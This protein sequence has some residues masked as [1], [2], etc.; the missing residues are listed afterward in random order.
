MD[1]FLKEYP[2]LIPLKEEIDECL[3]KTVPTDKD[4]ALM[5]LLM[6]EM[7]KFKEQLLEL[8]RLFT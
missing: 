1:E 7:E 8:K 5:I 4:E 3:L 6:C 2:H